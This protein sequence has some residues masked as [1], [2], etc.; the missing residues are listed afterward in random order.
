M[1]VKEKRGRRRYIAFRT[2]CKL[3]DEGLLAILNATMSPR[4]IKVPKVMQ[5]DGRMGIMRC[6]PSDKE[7]VL[8]ALAERSDPRCK[9]ETLSTSG[10]LLTLREKYFPEPDTRR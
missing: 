2:E 6:S 5:F 9:I 1:V 7:K 8:M 3:S 10:T 4:G